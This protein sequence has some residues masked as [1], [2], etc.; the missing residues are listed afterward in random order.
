LKNQ[1][2][3]N[4]EL[5]DFII[6]FL[7]TAIAILPLTYYLSYGSLPDIFLKEDGIY[8]STA[9]VACIITGISLL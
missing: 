1:F 2:V 9:A 5:S 4:R 7:L 8:E 3:I 6:F